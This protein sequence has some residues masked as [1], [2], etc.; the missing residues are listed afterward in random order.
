MKNHIELFEK[1]TQTIAV[2]G[3]GAG[4]GGGAGDAYGSLITGGS[5]VV[6]IKYKYK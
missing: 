4:A 5:G 3:S 1:N 6:V 2:W